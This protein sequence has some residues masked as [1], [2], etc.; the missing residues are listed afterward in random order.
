M[1]ILQ[2]VVVIDR[3]SYEQAQMQE[4]QR[5]VYHDHICQKLLDAERQIQ[6][7]KAR[8]AEKDEPR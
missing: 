4:A 3:A 7:L 8:L 6:H 2:D 1:K 5:Q